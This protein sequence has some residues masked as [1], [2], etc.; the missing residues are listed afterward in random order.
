MNI[1]QAYIIRTTLILVILHIL[2]L[3]FYGITA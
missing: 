3:E 2:F 1:L